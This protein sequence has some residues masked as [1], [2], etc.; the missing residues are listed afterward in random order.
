MNAILQAQQAYAPTQVSIR[1]ERSIE[2]QLVSRVTA[3]LKKAIST[4]PINFPELAA[5]LHSNRRMWTTLAA[6]VAEPDNALPES[7]RAQIFYLAEFTDQHS[8]KVLN[9]KA[10]ASALIDINTAVLR[11]LSGQGA[12]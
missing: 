7:L 6:E 8:Q 1:T 10:D 3:R 2:A 5:A 4:P 9:Q 11:G 12:T